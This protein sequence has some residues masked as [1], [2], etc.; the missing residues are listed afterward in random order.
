MLG[1]FVYAELGS[2]LPLVGGQ[3]RY[4][5]TAW[6]PAIGFLYGTALLFIINGGAIAA[7]ATVLAT[8]LDGWF[9][10]LGAIGIKV[11]AA[12]IIF[13]LTAINV[14]GVRAGRRTN[15]TLM[16]A[17]L[18]GI[19]SLV[20]LAIWKRPP[21]ANTLEFMPAM[22]GS[23]GRMLLTALVPVMFAYGGWQNCGSV[24]AEIRDPARTLARA[25]VLG[26]IAVIVVYVGLNV[27]YLRVL[28]IGALAASHAVAADVAR[29]LAGDSGGRLVAALIVVSSLGW[30][31]VIVFT[32]P[33]LYYAMARDGLFFKRAATLHPRYRTPA[34][35]LWFQACVAILLVLAN[36]YDAL[37]GYVVFADWLFFALA[38]AGLFVLRRKMP[39]QADSF[40]VPGH[41]VT[42]GLFLLVAV[43]IV[44]NSFFAWPRQSLIGTAILI[45]SAGLYRL[46]P[47][48]AMSPDSPRMD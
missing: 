33:R 8:H 22:S 28:P 24:A 30:L 2:R 34:F 29:A 17:K 40:R 27:L 7:V 48:A 37:L 21:P 26:V 18:A 47:R 1:G 9:I 45:L 16:I 10:P 15:N 43:G 38:A 25:N 32:G 14:I 46:T 12:V 4:L 41:P 13:A 3:Y 42:T 6:H 35:S 20:A 23:S 44:A 36:S 5:A 19:A 11:V 31:S 39:S